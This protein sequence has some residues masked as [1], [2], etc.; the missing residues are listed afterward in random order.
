MILIIL[1]AIQ[2]AMVYHAQHV[3]LAAAQEGARAAREAG[4]DDGDWEG[5]ARDAAQQ[6]INTLGPRLLGGDAGV[7]V[8]EEGGYERGVTVNGNAPSLIGLDFPIHKTSKGPIECFRPDDGAVD[9]CGD[10]VAAP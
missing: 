3:A 9:D 7:D 2:F 4:P 10:V 5:K 6:A 8:F 1:C